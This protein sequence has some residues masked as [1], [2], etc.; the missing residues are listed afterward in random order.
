MIL[1]GLIRSLAG[2]LRISANRS[3]ARRKLTYEL[4]N[5]AFEQFEAECKAEEVRTGRPVDYSKQLRLLRQFEAKESE[6]K[7]W[8]R[9]AD[10]LKQRQ[11]WSE[12]LAA[13]SGVK[14]PY[15]FG[16]IDMAAILLLCEQFGVNVNMDLPAWSRS[17]MALLE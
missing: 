12:K 7:K 16:L 11:A 14:L 6:R 3:H 2:M 8:I 15:A 10:R 5:A 1:Y 9:A 17:F 4:E 13:F